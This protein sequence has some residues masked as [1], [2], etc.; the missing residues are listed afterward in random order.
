VTALRA[1]SASD[2]TNCI[3]HAGYVVP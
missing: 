1:V 2:A 3:R